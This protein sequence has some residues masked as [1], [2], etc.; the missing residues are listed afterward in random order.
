MLYIDPLSYDHSDMWKRQ[1]KSIRW[2]EGYRA[3]YAGR[4]LPPN[5]SNEYREGHVFGCKDRIRE[6]N[7]P[8]IR[9]GYTYGHGYVVE[10]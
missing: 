8:F 6:M 3:G 7:P 10:D 2:R 4:G 9:G 1:G 5:S